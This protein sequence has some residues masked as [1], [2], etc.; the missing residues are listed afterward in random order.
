MNDEEKG[1][2]EEGGGGEEKKDLVGPDA[3]A[4]IPPELLEFVQRTPKEERPKLLREIRMFLSMTQS[5][6]VSDIL[7]RK[8]NSSHID[9][10]IRFIEKEDQ[11]SYQFAVG[12]RRYGLTIFCIALVALIALILVFVFRNE[13]ELL[14]QILIGIALILG[15]FGGGYGYRHRR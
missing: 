11:R 5:S 13:S 6:N 7:S 2:Q 3:A 15:G 10:L 9:Q 14:K 12:N 4:E 8:I 1:Q